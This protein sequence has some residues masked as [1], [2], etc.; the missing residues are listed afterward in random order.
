MLSWPQT[1]IPESGLIVRPTVCSQEALFRC[2][3]I[4]SQVA[5]AIRGL[6]GGGDPGHRLLHGL[7]EAAAAA[8][9]SN[10]RVSRVLSP[11]ATA[12]TPNLLK[13]TQSGGYF[14]MTWLISN[15]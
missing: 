14:L 6:Q 3:Y 5:G 11:E 8:A 13:G 2:A 7:S 9:R 1:P 12:P 15:A 10:R 4:T